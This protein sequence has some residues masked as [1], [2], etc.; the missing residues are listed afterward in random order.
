MRRGNVESTQ[1]GIRTVRIES[2]NGLV[3][4]IGSKLRRGMQESM[5]DR[6]KICKRQWSLGVFQKL[7]RVSHLLTK[8]A[9]GWQQSLMPFAA[10]NSVRQHI[11][12]SY[13]TT[14]RWF[15]VIIRYRLRGV[16]VGE[17]WNPGPPT[18]RSAS[19]QGARADHR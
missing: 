11:P 3:V 4:A 14:L 17:A 15:R 2:R 8:V 19:L 10:A 1:W 5:E 6:H 9:Q 16:R 13:R 12:M 18:R 7:P